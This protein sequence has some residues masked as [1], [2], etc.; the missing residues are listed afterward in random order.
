MENHDNIIELLIKLKADVTIKNN[1]EST[2][3]H[4]AVDKGNKDIIKR[5]VALN[6]DINEK[7]ISM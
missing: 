2:A 6:V 7:N 1:R 3:I 5:L 4:Y